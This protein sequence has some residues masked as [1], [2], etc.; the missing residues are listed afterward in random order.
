MVQ[1]LVNVAWEGNRAPQYMSWPLLYCRQGC[2]HW[3]VVVQRGQ[4]LATQSI[5]PAILN[6]AQT[7]HSISVCNL[8][9]YFS[10]YIVHVLYLTNFLSPAE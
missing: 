7:T 3:L 6:N 4:Y 9:G 5:L 2:P 1:H 8:H 10:N